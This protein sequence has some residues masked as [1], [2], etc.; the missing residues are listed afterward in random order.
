MGDRAGVKWTERGAAVA[1]S[2][3]EVDPHPHLTQ[4]RMGRG[5]PSYQVAS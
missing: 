3:G 4:C 2:V 5:L 1:L